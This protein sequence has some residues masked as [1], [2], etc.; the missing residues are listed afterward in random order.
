M[1]EL[2]PKPFK[3]N[4]TNSSAEVRALDG[5]LNLANKIQAEAKGAEPPAPVH[6]PV[7]QVALSIPGP[8]VQGPRQPVAEGFDIVEVE[9]AT[10]PFVPV[11]AAPITVDVS[12]KKIFF[13]GRL[14]AGKD[15]CAAQAN[16]TIVG[17]ADPLYYLATHFFGVSVDANAG[18][19][20]PGIRQFLQVVGQ[21]GRAQID[22]KYPLTTERAIFCTMIRSL[23][24]A[25]IISGNAVDWSQYGRDPDIWLSA[26]MKRATGIANPA[27][28]N[29]R[30][31]NEFKRLKEDGWV[32]WHVMT[33]PTSWTRR[34]AE[35]KLTP[36]SAE[37]ND[38]SEKLAAG[39]D[40]GVQK[41]MSQQRTGPKMRVIWNDNT[42]PPSP[43]FYTLQ[44]FLAEVNK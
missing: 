9:P 10:K 16:R 27:I 25:G 6:T 18:K 23:A 13:T 7:P 39:R 4:P 3:P 15:Y 24:A 29:V 32:D 2:T 33:T 17:L 22:I 31:E 12:G 19:D 43:R 5:M 8:I 36:Q 38:L 34:L 28:T 30:F 21:W 1:A 26:A 11:V 35:R 14:C 44:E 42:P 20:I 41:K 37:V 40:S